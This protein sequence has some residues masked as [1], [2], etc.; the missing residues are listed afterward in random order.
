MPAAVAAGLPETT[1]PWLPTAT[2]GPRRVTGVCVACGQAKGAS[3]NRK[4]ND[5][6]RIL[7]IDGNSVVV[8]GIH[9]PACH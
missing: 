7:R 4:T 5:I 3:K 6:E 8:A 9:C 1:T 2:L